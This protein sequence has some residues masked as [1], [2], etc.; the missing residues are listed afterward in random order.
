MKTKVEVRLPQ[1]EDWMPALLTD[2]R[3]YKHPVVILEGES[4]TR[5]PVEILLLR[6][7]HGSTDEVLLE[8]AR[9]AGF[10]IA[11]DP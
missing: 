3:N 1:D 6:G 10:S 7:I 5:G 9:H 8:A 4:M 11:H 2:E